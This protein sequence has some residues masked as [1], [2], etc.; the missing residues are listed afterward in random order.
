V[1]TPAD[2]SDSRPADGQATGPSD[3][4]ATVTT[5]SVNAALLHALTAWARATPENGAL[6]R[7]LHDALGAALGAALGS[8]QSAAL[9]TR[10]IAA[11]TPA[12]RAPTT[13]ATP[14]APPA[15][16]DAADRTQ[17]PIDAAAEGPARVLDAPR[18]ISGPRLAPEYVAHL[19]NK[20]LASGVVPTEDRGTPRVLEA[21]AS[22]GTLRTGRDGDDWDFKALAARFEIKAA[23]C[24]FVLDRAAHIAS[25]GTPYDLKD[26]YEALIARAKK[27]ATNLWPLTRP[28]E[29][30][31]ADRYTT[32]AHVF[33]NLVLAM[34]VIREADPPKEILEMVAEA[35]SALR[36]L[37]QDKDDDQTSVFLW[38]REQTDRRRIYLSRH[39]ADATRADPARWADLRSR[40]EATT[41]DLDARRQRERELRK[42]L[43]KAAYRAKKIAK[44]HEREGALVD[45]EDWI[46]L[47]SAIEAYLA[48]GGDASSADLLAALAPVA[49][50]APRDTWPESLVGTLDRVLARQSDRA[51][52]DD[53]DDDEGLRSW[54][55]APTPE[56]LK[57]REFLRGKTIVLVGGVRKPLAEA[58]IIQAF[59]LAGVRWLDHG[60]HKSLDLYRYDATRADVALVI[61]MIRWMSHAYDD[62]RDECQRA[63]T[64]YARLKGGYSPNQIAAQVWD[65]LSEQIER[66]THA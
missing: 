7:A 40:L 33:T 65:Q 14:N 32:L 42:P 15:S 66:A 17:P 13:S 34:S 64:L 50:A 27:A 51:Q 1:P 63:G 22:T 37:A 8:G 19:L 21:A 47:A 39:M 60:E 23:C 12:P 24:T 52:S 11:A 35:Q 5:A 31:D 43:E 41:K 53:A 48:A 61:V 16:G 2:N 4:A 9:D 6:A 38:L 58:A 20:G 46:A 59:D 28:E 25:G 10:V 54:E 62:L 44:Q 45:Q 55:R 36:A 57:L 56:L 26:R 18:P 29:P 49:S 3:A 30:V